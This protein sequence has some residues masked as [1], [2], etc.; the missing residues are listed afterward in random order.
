MAI[1]PRFGNDDAIGAIHRTDTTVCAVPVSETKMHPRTLMLLAASFAIV[2]IVGVVLFV[3]A[4]PSLNESGRVE[5]PTKALQFQA[6]DAKDRAVSIAADGPFLFSD[7]AGGERDIFLQHLGDDPLAGW[8]AFDARFPGTDRNCTLRWDRDRHLFTD[9]CQ[10]GVT[11][12]ANGAGLPSYPTS[13]NDNDQVVVE[14]A[15][16]KR[17]AG[18]T[19]GSGA[20]PASR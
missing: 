16:D 7:V 17:R 2:A 12:T 10:S 6:G 1:E 15:I 13:V 3:I 5:I 14:L 20:P 4:L 8:L 19:V 11:V 9:P 18:T